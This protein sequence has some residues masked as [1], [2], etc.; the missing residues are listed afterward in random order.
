MW[1]KR[2]APYDGITSNNSNNSMESANMVLVNGKWEFKKDWERAQDIERWKIDDERDDVKIYF[3]KIV[4]N[5][6]ECD[7]NWND[8]TEDW[9]F[10]NRWYSDDDYVFQINSERDNILLNIEAAI[11]DCE[12]PKETWSE[13]QEKLK[14]MISDLRKSF[15]ELTCVFDDNNFQLSDELSYKLV[16]CIPWFNPNVVHTIQLNWTSIHFI[17]FGQTVIETHSIS[18]FYDWYSNS[19]DE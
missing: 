7:D 9:N 10:P 11:E 6:I 17:N 18:D 15:Q 4:S 12:L 8:L 3:E 14:A 1:G 2:R 13:L 5:E 19:D 16:W